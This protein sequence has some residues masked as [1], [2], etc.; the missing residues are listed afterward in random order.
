[1]KTS[2]TLFLLL[3]AISLVSC[4]DAKLEKNITMYADTWDHI[5]N[6]GNIDLINNSN[7]TED[8]TLVMSPQN[9]VGIDG[10]KDY[11]QNFLTGFSDIK[12]TVV[13]VFGQGDNIVKHWNFKGNHT[14][15]FFGIPAT[16]NS[17]D[18]DGVTLVK[19][20]DGKI[21]QEEDFMDNMV[22]MQQLGLLPNLENTTLINSIYEAFGKGDIPAVLEMMD[23][24]IVWNESTSSS[25]SDGNPYKG[26]DAVLNGVFKRLGEDNEYFKLENIKLSPLGNDQVL[27]ILNY[28][29]KFK[30]TGEAY[31]TT[32]VH[33]WTLKNEKITTFQQYIGLGKQ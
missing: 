27:A 18:I 24:N 3:T 6:D 33:L 19:M 28:D 17:V 29:G 21:A 25:Y 10:F 15:D 13:Q 9:I 4:N 2:T 12:F 5:V 16:G 22:F 1:M 14:G 7:F 8:I 31:K 20:K 23:K 32:V 11:Y 26:P 30:K